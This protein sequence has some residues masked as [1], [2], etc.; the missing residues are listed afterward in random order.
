MILINEITIRVSY[1]GSIGLLYT[2]TCFV[3]TT[4][5][6]M[7]DTKENASYEM[8]LFSNQR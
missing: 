8:E 4:V 1:K 5:S 2:Q 7:D 3:K 6:T